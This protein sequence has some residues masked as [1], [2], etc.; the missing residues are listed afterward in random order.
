MSLE[1]GYIRQI[2][3]SIG[4]ERKILFIRTPPLKVALSLDTGRD[5]IHHEGY[6]VAWTKNPAGVG[7]PSCWRRQIDPPLEYEINADNEAVTFLTLGN[8]LILVHQ[9]FSSTTVLLED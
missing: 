4:E 5:D 6:R 7:Y 1:L 2:V 8:G 9:H 3:G